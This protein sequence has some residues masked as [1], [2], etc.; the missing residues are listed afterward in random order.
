MLFPLVVKQ[1][2]EALVNGSGFSVSLQSGSMDQVIIYQ[3]PDTVRTVII[4]DLSSRDVKPVTLDLE[5]AVMKT[6]PLPV[7]TVTRTRSGDVP[8]IQSGVPQPRE[9]QETHQQEIRQQEP[10]KEGISQAAPRQK[11]RILSD[12]FVLVEPQ[13]HQDLEFQEEAVPRE[14]VLPVHKIHQVNYDWLTLILLGCLVLFASVKNVYTKYLVYLLKSTVNYAT[15]A[16]LFRERT[17]SFMDGGSRLGIFFYVVF[18]VFAYQVLTCFESGLPLKNLP[19]FLCCI[20]AV[21]GYF[22]LKNVAYLMVGVVVEGLEETREYLFNLGNYNRVLG[23]FLFPFVVVIAFSP[24]LNPLFFLIP[25]LILTGIFYGMALLRGIIL[26]LK[27]QFSIFYLFLY[28]CTLEILPL[29]L[30]YKIVKV[31]VGF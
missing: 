28:L 8:K 2:P 30:I 18:S 13:A 15:S 6:K 23:L 16:R 21:P 14:V 22:L 12:S 20:V 1:Y 3:Q 10:R 29:F 17:Y 5:K 26:L 9:T 24:L 7:D 4:P 11:Q 31:Q 27:K 25:G 19:L